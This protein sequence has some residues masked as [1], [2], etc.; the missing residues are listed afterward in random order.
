ME[1]EEKVIRVVNHYTDIS[2]ERELYMKLVQSEKLAAVGLLAGNIAHELNN[3]LSGLKAMAQILK[4]EI[5]PSD[6]HSQDIDEI[7]KA[8]TRCQGIIKNL[9]NFSESPQNEFEKI[10]LNDVI[11]STLPLLKT[12]IRNQQLH[13]SFD[14]KIKSVSGQPGQLQQVFFNLI[15]NACQALP[16]GGVITVKTWQSKKFSCVSISD[17]GPGISDDIKS[18]IFEPFFTTKETGKGTGLGLSVSQ[19]IIEKHKGTIILESELGVGT[20]FTISIPSL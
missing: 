12:A 9:L 13:T 19:N 4:K 3:P 16:E 1:G 6:P 11:E 14:K 8:V 20:T 15:N 10:D 5:S 17:N 18:R 7:E 2:R